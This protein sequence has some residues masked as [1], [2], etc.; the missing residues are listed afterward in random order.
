M[1]QR[2]KYLEFFSKESFNIKIKTAMLFLLF[3]LS[4]L[5]SHSQLDYNITQWYNNKQSALSITFD[6]GYSSPFRQA[7]DMLNSNNF[8]ATFFIITNLI[9]HN[10][11]ANWTDVI[12]NANQG[13]EI[14]S[15]TVNHYNLTDISPE[16]CNYE[17]S[18]SRDVINSKVK[19]PKCVSLSYPGV[20]IILM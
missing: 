6:D 12:N 19:S 20:N 3:L 18:V 8:K 1:V 17:L 16:E 5:K 4:F 14:G 10:S 13:H 2:I 7:T 11:F 15:H 9:G